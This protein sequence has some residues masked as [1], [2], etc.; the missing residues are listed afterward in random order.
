MSNDTCSIEG[1]AT[2][3]TAD[4]MCAMHYHLRPLPRIDLQ[5]KF[6]NR[7][8]SYVDKSPGCWEW[9]G[10]TVKGY[11]RI[12]VNGGSSYA[13]RVSYE[14]AYGSIDDGKFIDHLCHNPGC[15]KPDHLRMVTPKQNTE[16]RV[17]ANPNSKS[18]VNGV[19]W[20]K[21]VQKWQ[22]TIHAGPKMHHVGY[23]IDLADAEAAAIAKRNELFTHNNVDRKAA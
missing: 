21:D 9:F 6:E 13:H 19:H 12:G 15:V 11:G 3:A 18:G 20:R 7:F 14:M 22:V 5:A 16:H 2:G 23:F 8:W 4:G 17:G 1:C 10:N